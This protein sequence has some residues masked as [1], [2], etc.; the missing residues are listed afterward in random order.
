MAKESYMGAKDSVQVQQ[1]L[2]NV[3][4]GWVLWEVVCLRM[5]FM[6]K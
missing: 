3:V 5:V 2:L 1:V 6:E 4:G